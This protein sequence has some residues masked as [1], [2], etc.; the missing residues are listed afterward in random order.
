MGC[1]ETSVTN[2]HYSPRNNPEEFS[3]LFLHKIPYF[4]SIYKEIVRQIHYQ[5]DLNPPEASNRSKVV[6]TASHLDCRFSSGIA[7]G[8]CS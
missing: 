1:P 7:S 2:Y 8:F 3:T 4:V 6:L 5:L